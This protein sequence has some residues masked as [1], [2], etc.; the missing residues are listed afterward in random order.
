LFRVTCFYTILLIISG[1]TVTFAHV[2][3]AATNHSNT[4]D[5]LYMTIFLGV[6]FLISQ[7]NEYYEIAYILMIVF[8]L[9]LF[10]CLLGYMGFMFLL[11]FF[12]FMFV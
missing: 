2:S 10:L 3:I 7:I 5:A 12:F 9:V 8:L 6:L 1:L 4:L 11:E